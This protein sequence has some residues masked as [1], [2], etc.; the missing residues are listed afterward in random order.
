MSSSDPWA[1][2]DC[3]SP[4]VLELDIEQTYVL[5]LALA[6]ALALPSLALASSLH[7]PEQPL[8]LPTPTNPQCGELKP[9]F[10]LGTNM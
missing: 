5:S 10:G 7:P 6:L 8:L 2:I 3:W 1:V 4:R 9:L